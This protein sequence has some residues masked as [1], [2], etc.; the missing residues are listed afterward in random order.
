MVR[1]RAFRHQIADVAQKGLIGC[2]ILRQAAPGP[3]AF[4]DLRLKIGAARQQRLVHR[5]QVADRIGEARPEP[6]RSDA[7]AGQRVVVDQLA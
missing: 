6:I 3:V 4:V 1:V 2:G 7:A 5:G